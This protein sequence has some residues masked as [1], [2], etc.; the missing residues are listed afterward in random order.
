MEKLK[1]TWKKVFKNLVS[2][3]LQE[4]SLQI[5]E[6]KKNIIFNEVIHT[7]SQSS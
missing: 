4:I 7:Y 6:N 5:F 2:I 3:F 1:I